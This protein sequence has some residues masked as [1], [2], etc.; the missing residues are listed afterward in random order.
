MVEERVRHW[1]LKKQTDIQPTH[2]SLQEA[3][4]SQD[5][6]KQILYLTVFSPLTT[7]T[8]MEERIFR[9][10]GFLAFGSQGNVQAPQKRGGGRRWLPLA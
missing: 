7:E 1:A 10:L 8:L 6:R 4:V 5:G 3:K 2:I 9:K